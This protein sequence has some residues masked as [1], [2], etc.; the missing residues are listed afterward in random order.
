M[1]ESDAESQ[2]ALFSDAVHLSFCCS[3]SEN[4]E[5]EFDNH[6]SSLIKMNNNTILYLREVNKF[7]ALVCILREDNFHKQGVIDYNFLCFREAI[8]RVFELKMKNKGI[9]DDLSTGGGDRGDD[10][11]EDEDEDDEDE[12]DVGDE[13]DEERSQINDSVLY[14]DEQN[15]ANYGSVTAGRSSA[16]DNGAATE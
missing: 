14:D 11:G 12:D 6:S 5:A 15:I 8:E 10:D 9:A 3:F 1:G 2:L 7:L 16:L 13:E 4:T